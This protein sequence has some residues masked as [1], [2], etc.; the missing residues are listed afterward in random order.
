MPLVVA[1][2]RLVRAVLGAQGV[3]EVPVVLTVLAGDAEGQLPEEAYYHYASRMAS[4]QA[5]YLV[6]SW[7]PFHFVLASM[8]PRL[9]I[10]LM[11]L[12][13]MMQNDGVTWK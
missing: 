1:R 12:S 8:V 13:M 4:L 9:P 6:L 3:L 2:Q 5:V 7:V 10:W 11:Q